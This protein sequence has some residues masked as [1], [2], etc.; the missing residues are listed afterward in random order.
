MDGWINEW[1]KGGWSLSLAPP[2]PTPTISAREESDV[3]DTKPPASCG[4]EKLWV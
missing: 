3:E 1:M 2:T 4:V